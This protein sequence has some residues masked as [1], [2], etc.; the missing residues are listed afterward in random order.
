M[1]KEAY[2]ALG[3]VVLILAFL[4]T[5]QPENSAIK[6]PSEGHALLINAGYGTPLLD[7]DAK[8]S[9]WADVPWRPLDQVWLG[10]PPAAADFSGRYKVLWDENNLYLLAEIIDDTLIDRHPDGL[11]KYWDDDCLEIF[12]DEDASG[13]NHQYNYNAFAYHIAL[14]GRVVD[15]QPDSSFAFFNDH[16]LTRRST[17]GVVSTWEV[18]VKIFDGSL[19]SDAPGAENTPKQLRSGKKI[20]FALAYCDND[21]SAERENFIGSVPVM[22]PDKNRGW[23]DAGIFGLLVLE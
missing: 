8:D 2:T 17:Q 7:G 9:V 1:N 10:Q 16:C 6:E 5:E 14:D 22:G 18:A 23:I 21:H 4:W 13:G 15:I 3:I 12:V 19:Y 20:G 11:L